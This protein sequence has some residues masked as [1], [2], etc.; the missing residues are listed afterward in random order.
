MMPLSEQRP[1][2]HRS[3]CRPATRRRRPEGL[4]EL[5]AAVAVAF[6]QDPADLQERALSLVARHAG[7][8]SPSGRAALLHA[9]AALPEDLRRRL[10]EA[11]GPPA[12][13]AGPAA[14]QA[15]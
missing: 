15:A 11:L 9:T 1:R 12:P 5:L 10:T 2:S 14:G 8:A 3:S 6:G 4:G 13:T 7:H